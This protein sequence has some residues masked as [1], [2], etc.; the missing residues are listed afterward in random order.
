MIRVATYLMVVSL[1]VVRSAPQATYAD[2]NDEAIHWRL[3]DEALVEAKQTHKPICLVFYT[4]WC[5]HCRNYSKV[6]HAPRVVEAS[7]QFV[8]V[9]L[10]ADFESGLSHKFAFDGTYIPRTYFLSPDGIPDPRIRA[11]QGRSQY[12]YDESNP[13]SLLAGMRA[14]KRLSR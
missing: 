4:T 11:R 13:A 14:A 12:L 7:R 2:W 9:R 3:Y 6:F 10:N 8:M 5:V 1:L